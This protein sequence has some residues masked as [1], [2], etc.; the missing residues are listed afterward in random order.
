MK[1]LLDTSPYI[2]LIDNDNRLSA[3]AKSIIEDSDN[4]IYLSVVSFWEIVIKRSLGGLR[5]LAAAM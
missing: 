4:Q 3:T 2:W 5:Q 1:Y